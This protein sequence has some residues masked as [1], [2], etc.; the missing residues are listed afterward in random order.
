METLHTILLGPYKYLLRSF[1]GR[2]QSKEKKFNLL[3]TVSTF[4]D[5]KSNWAVSYSGTTNHLWEE[6]LNV[7]PSVLY[8]SSGTTSPQTRKLSGLI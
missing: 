1:I 5:L 7:L 8:L 4:Q 3:Y 6:I 2:L